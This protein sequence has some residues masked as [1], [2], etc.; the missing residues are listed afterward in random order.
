MGRYNRVMARRRPP[1]DRTGRVLL[2]FA[3]VVF[4]YLSYAYLTLPDV[5]PLAKTNPSTTAFM[6]L[7]IDE[8]RTAGRKFSIRQRWIPY[9]QI[10][11]YL[12]RAVIVTED[13]AFFDHDGID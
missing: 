5:R 9:S 13:A 11:P 12:R 2:G 4:A 7:R 8:A 10:S 3:A 6:Q 1:F